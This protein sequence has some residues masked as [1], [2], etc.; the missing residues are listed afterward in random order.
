MRFIVM[1]KSAEQAA[2]PPPLKLMQAIA[3]LG[4]EAA[5]AGAFIETGGLLPSAT[6]ARIRLAA[7][8]ITVM[9]GPFTEAKEVIGGYA[10]YQVTSKA[11]AIAWTRRFMALHKEHWPGWEGECEI[12]QLIEGVP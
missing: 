1:V 9:D 5:K 11:E 4:E 6:G 7:G 12:R 8:E 2:G 3:R 10:I